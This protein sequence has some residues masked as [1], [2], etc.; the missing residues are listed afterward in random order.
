MA[1]RNLNPRG[2]NKFE[3]GITAKPAPAAVPGRTTAVEKRRAAE[4]KKRADEAKKK[5][6]DNP[7]GA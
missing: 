7:A 1:D 6:K 3:P 5:K 2:P 4:A